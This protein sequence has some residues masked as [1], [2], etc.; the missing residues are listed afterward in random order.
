[1]ALPS[2]EQLQ[3]RFINLADAS[4]GAEALF[5]SDDFFADKSR[6]LASGEPE[7]REG[8]YDE[9]GKWMDG[10][11]SR[12]KREHGFDFCIVKLFG[13]GVIRAVDIDTRY[14]TGN[15]PPVASLMASRLDSD[16]DDNTE[17]TEILPP[18]PILG[19]SHNIFEIDNES[20]FSH[21]K[22]NIFPDGGVAR[23]RVFGEQNT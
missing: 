9:H 3:E 16:P 10:W 21:L 5:A 7:W 15:Y 13:T 6:M 22:L 20:A 23:L 8:V 11:E 1:M 14:F 17:W 18:Q 4:A 19:D 2:I 12:R